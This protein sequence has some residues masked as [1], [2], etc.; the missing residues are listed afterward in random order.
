MLTRQTGEAHLSFR[1][2]AVFTVKPGELRD[3]QFG[4]LAGERQ[5]ADLAVAQIEVIELA[6]KKIADSAGFQSVATFAA[7]NGRVSAKIELPEGE[8]A[9]LPAHVQQ[10]LPDIQRQGYAFN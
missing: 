4:A 7:V 5:K 8:I 1:T 2:M 9:K 10:A 3:R 6:Q